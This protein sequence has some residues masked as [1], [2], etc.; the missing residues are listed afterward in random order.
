MRFQVCRLSKRFIAIK[1]VTVERS[2]TGVNPQM[3]L[4]VVNERERFVAALNNDRQSSTCHS[5][6]S[7]KSYLKLTFYRF[8]AGVHQIVPLQFAAFDETLFTDFADV[9]FRFVG[10]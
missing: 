1:I 9:V 4:H 3:S 6:N 7:K 2:F 8:S 5:R 10:V